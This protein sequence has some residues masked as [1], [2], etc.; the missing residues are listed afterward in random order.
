MV[1]DEGNEI[2]YMQDFGWHR[3]IPSGIDFE[4][5]KCGDNDCRLMAPG[6]GKLGVYGNG[7][8]YVE[9]SALGWPGENWHD[10][11]L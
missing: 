11:W 3:G 6:Y 7:C 9:W 10:E 8:L 5:I 2:I 1:F 4:I